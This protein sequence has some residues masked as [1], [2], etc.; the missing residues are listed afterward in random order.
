VKV[1][2]T[3]RQAVS[4]ADMLADIDSSSVYADMQFIAQPRFH[5]T[6]AAALNTLKDSIETRFTRYDLQ[7]E[8]LGFNLGN[9]AS[10]NILGRKPGLS[11]EKQ[12]IIVDGHFDAVQ[13]SPGADDNGSAVA[14][15]LAAARILSNY[16]FNKSINFLGFD[17]EEQGLVGSANYVNNQIKDFEQIEGVLNMEMIGYYSSDSN[18]Q[19]IPFGFS[20]LFPATVDSIGNSGNK[21]IF[22]FVVGNTASSA[23]AHVFDS[24][25]RNY[26]PGI[27]SLKLLV[28]GNGQI[29]QDLRRSD[30]A[31]FWDAGYQA[32]MLTDG[33]DFRNQ[34]Y[35]TPGDSLGT[36]NI[37][38]LVRN[39]RA[40]VAAAAV[41]AEP[42]SA[43]SDE[44]IVGQLLSHVAVGLPEESW[45]SRI[46][47]FP[48]PSTGNVYLVF[49]KHIRGL[50]VSVYDVSG[51]LVIHKKQNVELGVPMPLHIDAPGVY[52]LEVS[53]KKHRVSRKFIITETHRH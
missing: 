7:T 34:N 36:L 49:S 37:P 6:Q 23:L 39:I 9:I 29:A 13:N 16:Q 25:G 21:G 15:V 4:I 8:R 10:E 2:A 46:E 42:I 5:T 35:H 20:Q 51:R 1:S 28:P 40:V 50:D 52:T 19:Q 44:A 24:V 38:F 30:H 53:H 26:V 31:V 11:S 3:D 32:L 33:A 18:S 43:G 41:L 17:K 14:G 27:R 47:V 22:L 48:V 45:L 12:V